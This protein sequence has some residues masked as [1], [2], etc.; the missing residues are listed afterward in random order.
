MGTT[1][2]AVVVYLVRITFLF[3]IVLPLYKYRYS[4]AVK[5]LPKEFRKLFFNIF[6]A[7]L[8]EV[9]FELL[10]IGMISMYT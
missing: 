8:F 5:F 1:F 10:F 4:P 2:V 6:M 3:A 9:Y 7:G